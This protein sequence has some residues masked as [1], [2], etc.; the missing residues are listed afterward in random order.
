L[1]GIK[2]KIIFTIALFIICKNVFGV[3][4]V[5]PDTSG[6]AGTFISIPVIVSD[7]TGE[8][9]T[10]FIIKIGFNKD[11]IKPLGVNKNGTLSS[12]FNVVMNEDTTIK[13]QIFV[14]AA[15]SA[16][17]T[18]GGILINFEFEILPNAS[19]TT[20]LI[21]NEC[22]LESMSGS[23]SVQLKN[24]SITVGNIPSGVIEKDYRNDIPMIF[25]LYQNYPNP[26]NPETV[27]EYD[28][29][30]EGEISLKIFNILGQEV[31]NLIN[32]QQYP[33]VYKVVW[34]GRD[35]LGLELTS[36]VYFYRISVN[37]YCE[38]RKLILVK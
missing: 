30:E 32:S 24:G 26:F 29:A 13:D 15:S 20:S 22:L 28:L 19:G 5:L 4:V 25:K 27:I 21:F 8:N 14:A 6:E 31:R 37:K 35:N 33:G 34:D 3:E 17:I 9:I 23:P 11:I 16:P 12:G 7:L 18:G 38:I 2:Y 10:G 1:H 36:G